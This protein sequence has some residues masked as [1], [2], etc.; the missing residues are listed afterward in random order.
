MNRQH[1]IK[2]V[3]WK[4]EKINEQIVKQKSVF[5]TGSLGME[6]KCYHFVHRQ[7]TDEHSGEED[8]FD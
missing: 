3:T 5:R 1:W 8:T 6:Q 2:T 7:L 4:S